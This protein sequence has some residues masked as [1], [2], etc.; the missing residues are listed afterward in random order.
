MIHFRTALFAI[1]VACGSVS[2][3]AYADTSSAA[4][5][6]SEEVVELFFSAAKIANVE[7]LQ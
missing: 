2:A 3:S 4:I 1:G 6:G 7:V 5:N